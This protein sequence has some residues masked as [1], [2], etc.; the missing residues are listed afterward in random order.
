MPL[1]RRSVSPGGGGLQGGRFEIAVVEQRQ[2]KITMG[3]SGGWDPGEQPLTW[4]AALLVGPVLW[5]G[6]ADEKP[7][8]PE[9]RAKLASPA[10]FPSH[11]LFLVQSRAFWSIIVAVSFLLLL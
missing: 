1:K 5:P 4:L 10:R 9:L 3:R 11:N 2:P 6:T 8:R 7:T